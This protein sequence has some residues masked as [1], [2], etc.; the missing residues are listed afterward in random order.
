MQTCGASPPAGPVFHYTG[1]MFTHGLSAA[2]ATL[3]LLQPTSAPPQPASPAAVIEERQAAASPPA[4]APGRDAPA[5]ALDAAGA[6]IT[7]R[8]ATFNILDVR[9]EDVRRKDHPRLKAIA[10]VIQR[11]RPN[12]I[13]LNEIAYDMPGAP[14]YLATDAP[15]Q[16]G[17]RFADNYLAVPQAPGLAPLDYA[18]FTAPTNTGVFSGFDLDNNGTVVDTFPPPPPGDAAGR[19]GPQTDAGRAFGGDCWGFGTFPGQYGMALLV[20]RRL[21][22]DAEH[23]RTFQRLPWDYMPGNF[24]PFQ[25]DGTPWYSDEERAL[26]RLSSKSHWDV[27]VILPNGSTVHFLCSHPTPPTFDGPEDRNGKRNHDEIRFWMDYVGDAP[28]IVDDDNRLGGLGLDAHFVILGDL[29]ADPAGGASYKNPAGKLLSM[30]QVNNDLTPRSDVDIAGLDA[31]DT[32]DFKLRVDY[33]IPSRRL[34]PVRGGVWRLAPESAHG[35]FPSDHFPVW[36]ELEVPPGTDAAPSAGSAN[37][38]TTSTAT[39]PTNSPTSS[40]TTLP[41]PSTSGSLPASTAT[42]SS[43]PAPSPARPSAPDTPPT[44]K[45]APADPPYPVPPPQPI[46]K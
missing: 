3:T 39:S 40:P 19:P 29:N 1:G 11:L 5:P 43:S 9:T 35:V 20:D 41:S 26:F 21:M 36:M 12:V 46:E 28:W 16:N 22:I 30:P 32:S 2:L 25:P 17:Q 42:P 45:P 15:G 13:F 23:A 44:V 18:A 38:S 14:G 10:E 4:D 7:L 6:P 24:L 8:V 27:P 31:T 33:V 34:L 37:P